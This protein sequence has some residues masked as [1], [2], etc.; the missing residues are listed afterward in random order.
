MFDLLLLKAGCHYR[1]SQSEIYAVHLDVGKRL[2]GG[3]TLNL[4]FLA[5]GGQARPD[6]RVLQRRL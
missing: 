4:L 3:V 2:Q 1:V 6:H 5:R